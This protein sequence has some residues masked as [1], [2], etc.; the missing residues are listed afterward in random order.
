MR[1]FVINLHLNNIGYPGD[2]LET[3]ISEFTGRERSL[4][5]LDKIRLAI[6]RFLPVRFLAKP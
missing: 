2:V 6:D 3:Y 5:N 4:K 1:Y